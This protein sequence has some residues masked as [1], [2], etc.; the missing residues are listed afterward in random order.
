M[1]RFHVHIDAS[2]TIKFI[3]TV[4]QDVTPAMMKLPI[5]STTTGCHLCTLWLIE[6]Q[7][8]NDVHIVVLFCSHFTI[9]IAMVDSVEIVQLSTV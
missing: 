4:G 2:M 1:F 3:P 5:I 6:L 9:V 7:N 8:F